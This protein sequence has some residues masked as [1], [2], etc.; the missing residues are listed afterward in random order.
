MCT[1]CF[2][3]PTSLLLLLPITSQ[4]FVIVD[5]LHLNPMTEIL[6]FC[7][8]FPLPKVNNVVAPV[9]VL[10]FGV[11][12]A[13]SLP[14]HMLSSLT[15]LTKPHNKILHRHWATASWS[16][17]IFFMCFFFF[18][19]KH[20]LKTLWLFGYHFILKNEKMVRLFLFVKLGV[21]HCCQ[22]NSMQ[23]FQTCWGFAMNLF[24]KGF[25]Y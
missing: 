14:Q 25:V 18:I 22:S 21:Y 6:L 17:Y 3:Y 1:Q 20:I 13:E 2:R 10:E 23:S 19:L 4:T 8:H 12:V 24:K 9:C 7:W 5:G 15:H 16:V 11:V